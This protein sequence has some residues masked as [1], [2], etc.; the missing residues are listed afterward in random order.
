[1]KKLLSILA[2]AIASGCMLLPSEIPP[3][4]P[5]LGFEMNIDIQP[6]T[7]EQYRRMSLGSRGAWRTTDEEHAYYIR[8]SLSEKQPDGSFRCLSR[9]QI[10]MQADQTAEVHID[11]AISGEVGYV[12]GRY[13]KR[14]WVDFRM[15]NAVT[16]IAYIA[17]CETNN[18]VTT[19][20]DLRVTKIPI[21]T[22]WHGKQS[23]T[24]DLKEKDE[25]NQTN[26]R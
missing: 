20:V 14:E 18:A 6:A 23:I 26:G 3:T 9:P 7:A 22:S 4:E 8:V 11:P 24:L 21:G 25:S 10:M 13:G 15:I 2:L 17:V 1:M 5:F 16:G 12:R 19:S